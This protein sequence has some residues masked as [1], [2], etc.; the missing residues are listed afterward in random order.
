MCFVTSD[1]VINSYIE[2]TKKPTETLN[3]DVLNILKS[4]RP[5]YPPSLLDLSRAGGIY[6]IP[7]NHRYL[8]LSVFE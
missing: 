7:V 3:K 1:P 6:G 2:T 5:S 8:E 4:P